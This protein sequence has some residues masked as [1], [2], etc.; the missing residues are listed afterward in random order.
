MYYSF[1]SVENTSGVSG[2]FEDLI[3]MQEEGNRNEPPTKKV[4]G[5][6]VCTNLK[7]FFNFSQQLQN[8]TN[9]HNAGCFLANGTNHENHGMQ[10]FFSLTD[11]NNFL[12][13]VLSLSKGF[14]YSIFR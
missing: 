9:H 2:Q 5:A 6:T 10:T 11:S 12:Y 7:K 8:V 1:K 3:S 4:I 14:S 13:L